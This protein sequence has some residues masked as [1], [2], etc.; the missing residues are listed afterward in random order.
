MKMMSCALIV[1]LAAACVNAGETATLLKRVSTSSTI[2]LGRWHR[3]FD[4]A[5]AYADSAG[6]PFIAV[7]SNGDLCSHCIA[8]EKGL[9]TTAFKEW[10]KKSGIVFWFGC[11]DNGYSPDS[12]SAPFRWTGGFNLTRAEAIFSCTRLFASGGRKAVSIL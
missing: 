3:N 1:V 6:V 8:M 5:K 12:P 9:N 10:E 7:W 4:A 11:P 2:Q